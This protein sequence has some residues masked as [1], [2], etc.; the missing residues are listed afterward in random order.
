MTDIAGTRVRGA[1]RWVR[2]G[3]VAPTVLVT[4]ILG[5]YP[6]VFIIG[7]A[8]TRSSL[9]KPFQEFVAFDQIAAAATDTSVVGALVRGVVYAIIVAIASTFLGTVTALALWR[10][11]LAGATARVILLLPLA[12]PPVVV[13]VLWRLIFTPNG[14]L[15]D[16]VRRIVAPGT[17]PISF[18]S[19]PALAIVAIAIADIWEWA[20]LVT[21]LVFAALLGIDREVMEAASLDGAHGLRLLREI[22]IPAVLGTIAA[23][24]VIRLV[25]ALKVFDL[26]NVMTKGGPGDASSVPAW[27]VWKAAIEQFDVGRGAAIT[28]LLAVVVTLIT[29]PPILI[30]R[31]S[32]G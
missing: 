19:D 31:R 28:L 29:L 22:A 23:T 20:P 24:F 8:L 17:D 12:L 21:I 3:F 4:V 25:L 14:G 32:H 7:A 5:L 10:S 18:L 30:A 2:R 9:G 15:I 1:A 13:G 27:L 6:L 26:V 16:A 11:A